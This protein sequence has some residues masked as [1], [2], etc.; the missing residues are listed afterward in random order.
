MTQ[1]KCQVCHIIDLGKEN[2]QENNQQ[3]NWKK[4]LVSLLLMSFFL[5]SFID[6][7][8]IQID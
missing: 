8:N 7:N 2:C 4:M 6:Y 3:P 5:A 1:R